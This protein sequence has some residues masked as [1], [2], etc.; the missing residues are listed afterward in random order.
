MTAVRSLI[1]NLLHSV[2]ILDSD[3]QSIQSFC[4]QFQIGNTCVLQKKKDNKRWKKNAIQLNDFQLCYSFVNA[5]SAI[6]AYKVTVSH[7]KLNSAASVKRCNRPID[8][9]FP[10]LNI[11]FFFWMDL[12]WIGWPGRDCVPVVPVVPADCAEILVENWIC[13]G[14]RSVSSCQPKEMLDGSEQAPTTDKRRQIDERCN[15]SSF[16]LVH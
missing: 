2:R 16:S 4:Q 7:R 3:S 8:W 1:F 14:N 15:R 6:F 10:C 11:W 5:V 12:F 13:Q 9:I